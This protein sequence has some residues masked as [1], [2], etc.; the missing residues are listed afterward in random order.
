MKNKKLLDAF[1]NVTLGEVLKPIKDRIVKIKIPEN[2]TNGWWGDGEWHKFAFARNLFVI[3]GDDSHY[4]FSLND[5][6]EIL[7]DSIKIRCDEGEEKLELQFIV[8]EVHKFNE[9]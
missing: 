4:S 9:E 7:E 1:R 6:V 2:E 5:K 8:G 3:Y